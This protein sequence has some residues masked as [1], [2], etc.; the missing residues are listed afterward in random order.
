MHV[1]SV[2]PESREKAQAAVIVASIASALA[3]AW[4]IEVTGLRIPWWLDSPSVIGFYGIYWNW[5]DRRLWRAGWV[6]M[7]GLCAIPDLRGTWSGETVSSFDD[8]AGPHP[9]RVIIQQTWTR[10]I[11]EFHGGVSRSASNMAAFRLIAATGEIAYE[12]LNEPLPGAV[13]TMHMH[14]GMARLAFPVDSM[15]PD[16]LDGTYYTG[17]DRQSHGE[18]RLRRTPLNVAYR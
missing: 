5:F 17:R 8:R 13:A 12:Y 7:L 3:L 15:I 1:Y 14:R 11:V 2:E 4:L 18:I 9:V 6:R 16:R 10:I